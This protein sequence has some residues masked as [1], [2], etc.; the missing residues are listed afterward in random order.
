MIVGEAPGKEEDEKGEGFT[1]KSG[2]LL[3]KVIAEGEPG[4]TRR[5]F[6]VTN[7]VKCFPAEIKTPKDIHIKACRHWL[8]QEISDLKPRLILALGNTA[9]K[10]FKNKDGG[11]TRINASTEWID[12]LSA[13]VC[14]CVHP[15]AALRS[16]VG[17]AQFE[18]GIENFKEKIQKLGGFA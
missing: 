15:S 3:W 16:D 8:D 17:M 5:Y 11:I 2:Q 14:W 6:H 12:S 1:G 10:Y 9:L 7:V 13:W 18:D 4:L